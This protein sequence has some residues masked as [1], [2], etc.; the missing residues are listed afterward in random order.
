MPILE[1]KR[2][3]RPKNIVA[4]CLLFLALNSN[5]QSQNSILKNGDEF[6]GPFKSWLNVK[7]NF[8]AK[9]NGVNDD[10][11]AL[12]TAFD[13]VAKGDHGTTVYLPPGT[14]LITRTLL[15]NYRINV[16]VVGADPAITVIKWGG[17]PHG[18]MMQ[19]NGTAYSKFDRITFNGN[20]LANVGV[21]QSWDFKKPNFD[22]GN[23]YADDVFTDL[24]FG[25]NGG[26]LKY[27]FAE[28]TILRD[29]FIRISAAGVSLGNFN[30]LDIWIR[31]S[32]FQ[33][34]A[35]GVTN[36]YGAGNFRLYH[37]LFLN[38]TI[39][40]ISIRNTGGFS[41]R[42]NTSIGSKQFFNAGGSSNPAITV[43]QGN[44]VI[45]PVNNQAIVISNQGPTAFIN[46]TI[47]SRPQATGPVAQFTCGGQSTSFVIGNVFTVQNP[48]T[49]DN[50]NLQYNNKVVSTSNL[51][52][53]SKPVLPGIEPRVNR[54]VFEVPAGA[55]VG[56]I[57]A[58]INKAA[59]VTGNRPVV[60][61][62]YGNYNISAT[63]IIP[64]NADMQLTG[65]GYGSATCLTWSST[66]TGPILVITGPGKATL[67][68]ITFRGNAASTNILITNADQK[69]SRI[70]LQEFIQTGGK[71][72]LIA[73]QLDHAAV[74]GYNVEFSG[75]Q[76]A[77]NVIGGKLA[78]KGRPAEGR[79]II[80][81]GAESGNR[82]SHEVT[83]GGNLI[84]QDT[85]YEGGNKSTFAN[86]SGN[87]YFAAVGD[88]IST[89]QQT[90]VPSVVIKNF[91]GKAIFV[92]DNFN[93]RFAVSGNGSRANILGIGLMTEDY[94][95]VA[96]TTSPKASINMLLN[97]T[98]NHP[99][100]LNR[101]GSNMVSNIGAFNQKLIDDML[102][103]MLK[104]PPIS[105]NALPD[106][107]SD[108][109]FYRVMSTG[110]AKGLDIEAGNK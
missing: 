42:D 97:R 78:A 3:M 16:S 15:M 93:D 101:T 62:P 49:A 84:V 18:T 110:G 104:V 102:A 99:T 71:Q 30:A 106:G 82:I 90:D 58:V 76:K 105:L 10:T 66:G 64:P 70:Y 47:R 2:T 67:R 43:I 86:L 92:A 29:K 23:E 63:L 38:S 83:N 57:Q 65:D 35:V 94:P 60:H 34:C 1:A 13:A 33:D 39:S 40:D 48:V 107:V 80:Y 74:L 87:G 72:G 55:D 22:T 11:N 69:G 41:V 25:I 27:G 7:D 61:F 88:R 6:V 9:G 100:I 95:F 12:Q 21:E 45:D 8:G 52:S 96:D 51:N 17:A 50:N 28:T 89:P 24:V 56:I 32:Y 85:W 26:N 81:S 109:R 46:N 5:A 75:L 53:L 31:D 103:N 59:Q 79:T 4:C 54:Q 14:Y 108:I 68:D 36:T 20:R 98:R 91:S 73:N 77:V 44:T 37:N 19:V